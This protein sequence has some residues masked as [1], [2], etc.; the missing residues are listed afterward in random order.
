ME[1]VP[2]GDLGKLITDE[3]A[4]PEDMTRTMANQLLGALE[5][6]HKNNITHR[7]VKPDN[8]LINSLDPLDVKLTDF[9]LSKMVDTEQTFLRTFC[10]TLL[11]CAPEVYTEFAEYDDNGHRIRG[12]KVRRMPGQ[13]YNH[14]VDIWSLGGVLFF[15]LTRSP[16][17]PVRT[18]ISYTELLNKIMTTRLNVKPLQK[19]GVSDRGIDFLTRML[20][21]RPENRA[22]VRELDGH[23]WLGGQGS[24]IDASQS[25]DEITDDEEISAL[26]QRQPWDDED[27]VSDSMGE[28]SEKEN[29]GLAGRDHSQPQRLFGEV[30]V[31]A[32][33][34]SGVIPDDFLNLPVS[35]RETEVLDSHEEDD[36]HDSGL[37]TPAGTRTYRQNDRQMT[38]SIDHDQSA[39]QLQSL[40]ENVASQ[41]LGGHG[42]DEEPGSLRGLSV[43][44]NTSKRK[45]PSHD[46]SDE[47][48]EN[49]PLDKPVM[50][51]LKSEGNIEDMTGDAMEEAKLLACMPQIRRLGS[52]RQIDDAVDKITYWEQD[53]S[54]WHLEYPEMTLLQ[55]GAFQQAARDSG[56]IFA[57]GRTPL[58]D[59][60]MRYFPSTA[61]PTTA[62]AAQYSLAQTQ[63]GLRRDDRKMSEA[64]DL[65]STALP[66]DD[67]SIPDTLRPDPHIVVPIRNE[68]AGN[69]ALG[70]IQSTPHSCVPDIS[71]AITEPFTSFGR[72]P[73]NSEV[74]GSRA[75][76]KVPKFAFK[77]MLWKDGYDP[78]RDPS[79]V[80][81]PWLRQG[82]SEDP[83]SFQFWIS[84]KAT[85][86]I[87]VNGH[88][89]H[90]D[91]S[92]DP[93]GPSRY[94]TQV[95]NGDEIVIWGNQDP[96]NQTAATFQCLWGGSKRPR[97]NPAV[98]IEMASPETAQKLDN[99]CQKAERRLRDTREKQ[100]RK[101]DASNDLRRRQQNI[102][103]ERERSQTFELRRQKAVEF[104]QAKA[105]QSSRR[106][107]PASA[108]PTSAL[109]GARG[110]A[111]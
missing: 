43:D 108:P 104:L 34:S 13:R 91:E 63:I 4:L 29:D 16:P 6:L 59:L 79:K 11:Y 42:N 69:M 15:T 40:V 98:P 72:H 102:E 76:S 94:W 77:L 21:R 50:K 56:Q 26:S 33:G 103:R 101:V 86:G 61:I 35:M 87:R 74:F 90:S 67:G 81:P 27:R 28:D 5:Y 7:D 46:T 23:E 30:G 78:A 45:P 109:F 9:G 19:Y 12:Q 73:D 88:S 107:S 55:L 22:T 92:R 96:N 99:A 80:P 3:G 60:A 68:T 32:I 37:S 51:R 106:A 65:P 75:E 111:Y 48:D 2:G 47:F 89:L 1:F 66:G 18:G 62:G 10:G 110:H 53:R 31:S 49:V 70:F 93:S 20:Q 82:S 38:V 41:S 100:R 85:L 17:Y 95:Y 84:T 57:P 58:W 39:D 105:T 44:F 8:I 83:D 54:T 25:Y 36:A 52:G 14:A 71:F 24:I 97:P 64:P